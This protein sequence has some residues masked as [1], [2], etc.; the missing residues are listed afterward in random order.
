MRTI[1]ATAAL[2]I[3]LVICPGALMAESASKLA[4]TMSATGFVDAT[5]ITPQD[6]DKL[7]RSRRKVLLFDSRER[8]E[9]AV[10]HIPRAA[11][12]DPAVDTN[13]LVGRVRRRA[14]GTVFVFYCTSMARSSTIAEWAA[15][16]LK[17]HGA[18]AVYVLVKGIIGW[19]NAG[20][21]LVDK[22]GPTMFVHPFD[23][24]MT[25]HLKRSDLARFEPPAE[26]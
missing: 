17:A 2:T 5:P 24:S 4:F 7:L 8:T 15:E 18:E 21:P 11:R 3:T 9:F 12:L 20:L 16:D 6:L 26:R 13:V 25:K 23:K 1:L 14:K 10:S 22:R 19:A